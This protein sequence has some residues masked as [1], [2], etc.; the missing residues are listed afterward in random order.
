MGAGGY[1][2]AIS[3]AGRQR[4]RRHALGA[5]AVLAPEAASL[6]S[7]ARAPRPRPARP[8]APGYLPPV[9]LAGLRRGGHGDESAAAAPPG[10][11][12]GESPAHGP[13]PPR[14]PA[15][16]LGSDAASP[17]RPRR[18]GP[19]SLFP[20]RATPSRPG[21]PHGR[22]AGAVRGGGLGRRRRPRALGGA[23]A[24]RHRGPAPRPRPAPA[25][26]PNRHF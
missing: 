12:R 13:A 1:T 22:R 18:P 6:R 10:A 24:A 25:F 9:G 4:G 11:R 5:W 8:A 26:R 7:A 20:G 23:R 19:C 16:I 2:V 15:A 14:A 21:A 3:I 17:Q